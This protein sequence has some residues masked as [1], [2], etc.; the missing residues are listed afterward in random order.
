MRG[1]M[2]LLAAACVAI[3]LA[4]IAFWPAIARAV[5][6]WQASGA[7]TPAPQSL[8][9]LGWAHVA[10]AVLG[11]ALAAVLWQRARRLEFRRALTWDCGYVAPTAR[12]QYTAG[13]FAGIIT[14]WFAWILRPERH[15]HRPEEP[16][17][18][19]ADYES[20]TPE[21]VL[22][23]LVEPAGGIVMQLSAAA[24]R[25]Q[26]G[27]LQSYLFYLLVGVAALAA[28]VLTGNSQ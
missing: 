11:V 20:H 17:P 8:F 13:S 1:S 12:M 23:Q 9:V 19:R 10:L 21:T 7:I 22:E 27:R 6:A 25:L 14:E 18:V 4:P 15:E 28:L 24:R 5:D 3:G 2:A 16:F 26:H